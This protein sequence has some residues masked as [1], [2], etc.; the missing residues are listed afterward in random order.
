MEARTWVALAASVMLGVACVV[1]VI[2]VATAA[3]AAP[4]SFAA[5]YVTL[6]ETRRADFIGMGL[7]AHMA[8]DA[9]WLQASP[10]APL[11]RDIQLHHFFGLVLVLLSNVM[12]RVKHVV[13]LVG[14][15]ELSTAAMMLTRA[16][17]CGHRV[18][19]VTWVAVRLVV[20]PLTFAWLVWATRASPVIL[21]T[22]AIAA[23]ASI[24]AQGFGWT[25]D[26]LKKRA[27]RRIP[28]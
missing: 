13:A 1:E 17:R 12:A 3:A 18:T 8:T 20:A 19:L 7:A 21:A 24:V 11:R 27:R 4:S 14:L 23:H 15:L 25:R 5:A 22:T 2:S 9:A 10:Q 28:S 16:T 6:G 26:A